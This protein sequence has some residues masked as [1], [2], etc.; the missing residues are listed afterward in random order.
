VK[1]PNLLS[2]I[3]SFKHLLRFILG[4][5]GVPP[6]GKIKSYLS[7]FGD[8]VFQ[9]LKILLRNSYFLLRKFLSSEVE[10]LY[11]DPDLESAVEGDA[12][13]RYLC[14]PIDIKRFFRKT[15]L[16]VLKYGAGKSKILGIFTSTTYAVA[17]RR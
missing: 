2:P 15:G 16:K 12:D 6:W 8:T 1:G 14:N 10:F 17:I 3:H 9:T 7:P 11:R 5:N 4:K 13:A